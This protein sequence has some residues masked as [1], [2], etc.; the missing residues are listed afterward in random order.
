[1]RQALLYAIDRQH[2]INDVLQGQALLAVGPIEPGTWAYDKTLSP[3]PFDTAKAAALLDA[4]GWK[5]T[6][7][8]GVRAKAQ[9]PLEFTL[10]TPDDPTHVAIANE[11]A[12]EWQAVGV[13]AAVQ[14]V[15]ASLLVQ[16]V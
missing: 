16:N 15:P 4:A 14:A 2:L 9:Q 10:I 11:I 1:M 5:D 8:D 3:Y 7:G 6:S 13:K 12:K